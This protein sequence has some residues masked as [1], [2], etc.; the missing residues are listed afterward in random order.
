MGL[1]K[2]VLAFNVGA[3]QDFL[4]HGENAL[5]SELGDAEAINSNI[6]KLYSDDYLWKKISNNSKNTFEDLTDISLNS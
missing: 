3:H 4:V 1:S 6:Q 2:P 5:V